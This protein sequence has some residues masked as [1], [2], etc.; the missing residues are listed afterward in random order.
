M[1]EGTID[2]NEQSYPIR[3]VVIEGKYY[4]Q[5]RV[6]DSGIEEHEKLLE[7]IKTHLDLKNT[8]KINIT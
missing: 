3:S 4:Q 2:A 6:T 5:T 8:L 1:L 7:I